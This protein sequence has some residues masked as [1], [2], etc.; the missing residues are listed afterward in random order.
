[1]RV[2]A[3]HR[4]SGLQLVHLGAGLSAAVDVLAQRWRL[5][6]DD[7][8]LLARPGWTRVP[9]RVDPVVSAI[10]ANP[11]RCV[12][13]MLLDGT[14][15]GAMKGWETRKHG[16]GDG[17]ADSG[18]DK[19]TPAARDEGLKAVKGLLG[20][21]AKTKDPDVQAKAFRDPAQA[22]ELKGKVIETLKGSGFEAAGT[23]ERGE[24][25]LK[26]ATGSEV[27]VSVFARTAPF[28][29][30]GKPVVDHVVR[31][32]TH[33]AERA[34]RTGRLSPKTQFARGPR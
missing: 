1:M 34:A 22:E 5:V 8:I 16:A 12:P 13:T 15:E 28:T 25:A 33:H 23:N 3:E 7:G 26:H 21:D 30:Q 32:F 20:K 14:S 9:S 31:V 18:G 19:G 27:Q 2:F 11:Q 17:P 29:V 6:P 4:T 24:L 10:L